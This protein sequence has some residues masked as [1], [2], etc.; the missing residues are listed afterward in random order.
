MS[1]VE[2]EIDDEKKS[3]QIVDYLQGPRKK[4]KNYILTAFG[5]N[6]DQDVA[7]SVHAWVKK[8]FQNLAVAHP[9]NV[10]ELT[11]MFS[12]QINLLILDDHFC[13]PERLL[14]EIKPLKAKKQQQATPVLFFTDDVKSL[15]HSYH[16][17]LLP[18]QESDNYVAYRS[19]P[20]VQVYSR[21]QAAANIHQMRRSRRFEINIPVR[22]FHLSNN[23]HMQASIVEMS[24]HGGAIHSTDDLIFKPNDQLKIHL[25]V[26]GYLPPGQGEFFRLPAKVRRVMMGGNKA[27]VSWEHLSES[28]HITLTKFV[29][30]YINGQI[31]RMN[32]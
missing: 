14:E 10:R 21:I 19:M 24:V 28:Q 23:Q 22:Y 2:T 13:E 11:R 26:K 25:P 6:F 7:S 5:K 29:L 27:A 8:N 17:I 9:R 18:Y 1:A 32:G 3:A 15:I 30:E 16:K 4:R 12:R 20:M 31:M